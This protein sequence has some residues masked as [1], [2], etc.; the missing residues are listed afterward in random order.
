M[1]EDL[2]AHRYESGKSNIDQKTFLN[3]RIHYCK[4]LREL[5][6][7]ILKFQAGCVCYYYSG[8]SSRLLSDL[9]KWNDWDSAIKDIEDQNT[10][11]VGAYD[12]MKVVMTQ[13][14]YDALYANHIEANKITKSINN[15][16]SDLK[17]AIE[18]A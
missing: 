1:R 16:V 2:Y 6:S 15:D 3:T 14:D 7:L 12:L 9:V 11:F 10:A 8:P 4:K 18:L 13:E 5:Y 17:R